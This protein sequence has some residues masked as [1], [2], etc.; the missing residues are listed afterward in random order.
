MA[1]IFELLS[2]KTI[3]RVLLYFLDHS[4]EKIHAGKLRKKIKIAKKSMFDSLYE[5]SKAEILEV[6]E[7]GRLKQYKLAKNK[8]IVKQLKIIYT[9]DRVM[10]FIKK[11]EDVEVYL[12]GSA[13]RGEDNE[14]SDIDL[15]IVGN[16]KSKE[17]IGGI[18]NNEK[19]KPIYF[20]YLEYSSLAR[21]DK[22]FYNRIER[23]KIRL[24]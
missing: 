14:K 13:A 7:I 19:I 12:Y 11:L 18:K 10:R 4:D 8:T 20:T 22:A 15:L 6:E 21:K 1:Q 3:N 2:K 17:I 24:I 9:V 16:K 23:D 5:L